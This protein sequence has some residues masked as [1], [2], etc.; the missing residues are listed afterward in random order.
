MSKRVFKGSIFTNIISCCNMSDSIWSLLLDED[1]VSAQ[2]TPT[3]PAAP[4]ATDESTVGKGVSAASP[5]PASETKE[6]NRRKAPP[7]RRS[8]AM[9]EAVKSVDRTV[10]TD[11]TL[12]AAFARA[13]TKHP[14]TES[15]SR[16]CR[17]VCYYCFAET[18]QPK[19]PIQPPVAH[20]WSETHV[21]I[22]VGCETVYIHE[23]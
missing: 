3:A 9:K 18:T 8:D 20:C 17:P 7:V 14:R 15:P 5:P 12:P 11:N 21:Y 13:G 19:H 23:A 2:P 1:E 4:T 10:Q 22:P 16:C 6:K